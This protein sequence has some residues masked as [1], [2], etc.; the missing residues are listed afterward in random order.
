VKSRAEKGRAFASG[1]EFREWL[2]TYH[3]SETE[4]VVRLFKV[5][6]REKGMTYADALDEALCFGWI[7]GVRRAGDEDSFTVRFTPRKE[8][9]IWSTVNI[10]R[11]ND[12]EAAGRMRESGLAAFRRRDD[13]R[14]KIY[15]YENRKTK[16]SPE[17][18]TV[19]RSSKQAWEFFQKQPPWYRRTCIYW[20]MS[21]KRAETQ[22]KRLAT[23]MEFS[24]KRRPIPQ[25]DRTGGRAPH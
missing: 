13:K 11:A 15:A 16:L 14:S 9:S 21:A 19:L 5:H 10:K 24:A 7:D 18:E 2:A 25:L 12:L 17:Y 6:A 3:A 20:L 23:L 4:L 1:S 8:K 22:R